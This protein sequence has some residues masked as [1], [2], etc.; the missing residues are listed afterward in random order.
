[1]EKKRPCLRL[2]HHEFADFY[3]EL[4]DIVYRE[5]ASLPEGAPYYHTSSEA[6]RKALAIVN[7]LA[8]TGYLEYR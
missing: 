7:R 4:C 3:G 5:D 6:R 1:M 8:D 2:T